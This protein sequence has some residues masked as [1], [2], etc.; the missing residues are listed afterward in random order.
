MKECNNCKGRVF[1]HVKKCG[2]CGKRLFT[3]IELQ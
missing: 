2:A 1:D 3:Q